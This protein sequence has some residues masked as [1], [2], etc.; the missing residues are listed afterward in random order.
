MGDIVPASRPTESSSFATQDCVEEDQFQHQKRG[1]CN[2]EADQKT[3]GLVE[4]EVEEFLQTHADEVTK[5]NVPG[6]G[7]E[8][9]RGRRARKTM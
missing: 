3:P 2:Y 6:H 8:S 9:S 7:A 5:P 1:S 4:C